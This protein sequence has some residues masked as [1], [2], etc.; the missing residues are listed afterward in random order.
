MY[1]LSPEFNLSGGVVRGLQ[2][3]PR[4]G[5]EPGK[6]GIR[7]NRDGGRSLLLPRHMLATEGQVACLSPVF[8]L[9]E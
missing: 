8:S 6:I 5:A 3:Q 4:T 1:A 7:V 9:A 2:P